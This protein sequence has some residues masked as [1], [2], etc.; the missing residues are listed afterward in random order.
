MAVEV[1]DAVAVIGERLAVRR[2]AVAR[3]A[4]ATMREEIPDYR[5][6]SDDLLR[7]D[8]LP[9]TLGLIDLLVEGLVRGHAPT[10][11]EFAPARDAGTRRVHQGISLDAFM[12]AARVWGR[13]VWEASL[14]VCAPEELAEREAALVIAGRVMRHVDQ[15]SQ[16]VAD[17]YLNE[18][19]SVWSDR[20][21]VRRD[22]LDA[23]V[24]GQG[25]HERIRRLAR[26]LKVRLTDRYVVVIARGADT[27]AEEQADQPLAARMALRRIVEAARRHLRAPGHYPLVGMRHGEVV[28]LCPVG[29]FAE[30][31]QI[32]QRATA[33]A[34]ALADDGGCVGVGG[35]H[36]T[37]AEVEK[38]YAEARDAVEIAVGTGVRGRPVVFDQVL[39]D[40]VI[41]SS[42]HADRILETTLH[43]LLAYDTA[44][45]AE[46]V[47]TLRAYIESGFSLTRSAER[48]CVHPNTVVYRLRRVRELSGRDPQDADDLLLL[49]L[50]LK[51]AE[52]HSG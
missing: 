37:L 35:C 21:V 41:R 38:S 7:G 6:A 20:E 52:L 22:L 40:Q 42:P 32:K 49:V 39:I 34:Q 3:R 27:P 31:E 9:V 43:P 23:L 50:G 30:V 48:L 1:G 5:H 14:E 10:P 26:S 11:E 2:D 46:L 33:L 25:D 45:R 44:K 16:H 8:V 12:R 15:M 29:E 13:C 51:L 18:L 24:C 19:Q 17:A 28:A 4:V 47:P 36:L